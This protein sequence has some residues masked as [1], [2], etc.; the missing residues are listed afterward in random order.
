MMAS[1]AK[2]SNINIGVLG[3][4]DSGKTS[5]CRSL[6]TVA[7]TACFDKNPQSQERGITLDLG[8][9]SFILP[10]KTSENSENLPP[11]VQVTLVD[12]PGHAS[13]IRTIIGG[14]SIIDLMILVVDASKGIQTQ[15]AECIVLAEILSSS[16]KLPLI[17]VLNKVDLFPEESRSEKV[18]KMKKRLRATFK[19]T[20]FGEGIEIVPFSCVQ[21][22][23]SSKE[24]TDEITGRLSSILRRYVS[25][26][27]S[28]RL[29]TE[30]SD[31][32]YSTEQFLFAVDHCFS[33]KGQGTVMTGTCLQ[34]KVSVNDKIEIASLSMDK[35]VKSIQVFRKPVSSIQKGDRAGVCVTQFESSSL[36]RG[37]VCYPGLLRNIHGCVMLLRKVRFYKG[38]IASNSKF[39]IVVGHET[40]MAKVTLFSSTT[41][42]QCRFDPEQ[43][44]EFCQQI[45]EDKKSAESSETNQRATIFMLLQF[46][47]PILAAPN[48][49]LIGSKLD[50]DI[51]SNTCRIAFYGKPDTVFYE[52]NY[53]ETYLS[54]L[55]VF[56]RKQKQGS[57][58]RIFSDDCVICKNMLKKETNIEKFLRLKV[59]FSSGDKGVIIGGFGQGGKLKIQITGAPMSE[60]LKAFGATSRKSKGDKSTQNDSEKSSDV[61]T[62]R[63]S[64][65]VQLNFKKMIF[66][67]SNISKIIQ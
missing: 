25:T 22:E 12:C 51:L 20:V 63:T 8:F 37:L 47:K 52:P 48:S 34:G 14:A 45:D 18:E 19:Q 4:V 46:E 32:S 44:Y 29:A 61:K 50:S 49:I 1:S 17:V 24:M 60:S 33:I 16:Q 62:E 58:D 38:A 13:L 9:S 2:V 7:S 55:K 53:P 65:A 26:A 39:H 59:E 64:I 21:S 41:G 3:H 36:E 27:I 66:A 40:V 6:S 56:K 35:K 15:T 23:D 54:K 5:L 42:N 11:D 10:L 43:E 67:G 28:A 57:I 30:N 31:N